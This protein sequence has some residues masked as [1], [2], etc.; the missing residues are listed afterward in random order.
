MKNSIMIKTSWEFT[1]T[2]KKGNSSADKILIVY[3]IPNNLNI[4]K[5]GI[6]IGKKVGGSVVRNGVKRLIRE[7][8]RLIEYGVNV[9]YTIVFVPRPDCKDA[10]FF[11]IKRS[12]LK[13]FNRLSILIKK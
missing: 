7:N 10:S 13:N 3:A 4:N 9:G 12:M 6:S 2:I 11:D 5:I 1:K 8:Y